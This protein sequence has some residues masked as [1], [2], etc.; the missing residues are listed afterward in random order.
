VGRKEAAQLEQQGKQT[1]AGEQI[2]G[3]QGERKRWGMCKQLRSSALVLT[4]LSA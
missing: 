4:T 2:R 3:E 1:T